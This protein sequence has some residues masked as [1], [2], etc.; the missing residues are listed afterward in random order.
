MNNINFYYNIIDSKEPIIFEPISNSSLLPIDDFIVD[1]NKEDE[2]DISLLQSVEYFPNIESLQFLGKKRHNL[3]NNKNNIN[4]NSFIDIDISQ[5]NQY[6]TEEINQLIENT[7]NNQNNEYLIYDEKDIEN[8][9]ITIKNNNNSSTNNETDQISKKNIIYKR[10]AQK[11]N[12]SLKLFK[13]INNWICKSINKTIN[14][15]INKTINSK[16]NNIKV[17]RPNY[18]IF[19]HNSNSIDIYI[20]LN[21]KFKY[22]LCMSPKDKDSFNE[23]LIELGIKKP[24][25]KKETTINNNT[26]EYREA[27]KLLL[28]YEYIKENE[29]LEINKLNSLIIK[30]LIKEGLKDKNEKLLYKKDK[31]NIIQLLIKN[32][33]K[34]SYNFQNK[35]KKIIAEI[36]KNKEI[37]ELNMTLKELI[38]S[39]YNSEEFKNFSKEVQD[40]NNYVKNQKK[41]KYSLL[42]NEENNK[43]FLKM[44]EDDCTLSEEKK[45]IV[46]DL[47]NYFSDKNI[48]EEEINNYKKK[49]PIKKCSNF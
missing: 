40:I 41:N 30:L 7:N 20:F 2:L 5:N 14:N 22:I 24:C 18:D 34:K 26:K 49:Y 36:E 44:I 11:D 32:G 8:N 4:F 38:I 27:L 19:T 47:T 23:L 1:G 37:K 46:K 31:D 13:N 33:E 6:L 42:D 16:T 43:G 3:N 9:T 48:N 28:K 10:A 21:I 12:F 29:K 25:K 17:H 39:F 35:N 15:Y 45:K